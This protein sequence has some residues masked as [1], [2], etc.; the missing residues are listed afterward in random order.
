AL[1]VG[2]LVAPQSLQRALREAR[3]VSTWEGDI[4]THGALADFLAEGH[5]SAHVRRASRVYGERRSQLLA[6]LSRLDDVLEVVPSVA[7][8]HVC[9]HFRDQTVDD[10]SVVAE[11]A[12]HGVR[13]EALTPR[14][15]EQPPVQGLVMGIGTIEVGAIQDAARRLSRALPRN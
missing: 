9:A 6:E 15:F 8:L 14:Y 5:H 13:V 11:A 10:R 3:R 7:G 1:R 2:Y 4:V 12:R